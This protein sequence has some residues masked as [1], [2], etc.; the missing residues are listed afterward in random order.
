VKSCLGGGGDDNIT[1]TYAEIFNYR[2]GSF[3]LRYLGVPIASGR[4]HVVDWVRVEEKLEKKLDVWQGGSLSSGGR[5]I[6]IN[7]S[8]SNSMIYHMP[9]F[10]I[11]KTNIG[12]MDK[13]RSKFFWQGGSFKKKYHL[14][15]WSKICRS[16]K[17]GGLGIK[18]LRLM[19][20]SLLCK[21]WWMLENEKGLEQEL[22]KLKYVKDTLVCLIPVKQLD[23]LL[24]KDLLKIRHI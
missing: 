22:V 6:M 4:L 5:T 21:W 7:A 1:V 17:N 16:K 8:F 10:M 15:K 11:P 13:M 23:S 12:R 9:M 19:N 14:V 2:I 3:P 18:D 20:V 24:W